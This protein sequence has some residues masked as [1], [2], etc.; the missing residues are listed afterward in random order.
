M[1]YIAI[2]FACRLS[3]MT[4][5]LKKT[6]ARLL[7]ERNSLSKIYIQRATLAFNTVPTP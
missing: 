4:L 7:V 1:L 3:T 6:L 5:N 2:N